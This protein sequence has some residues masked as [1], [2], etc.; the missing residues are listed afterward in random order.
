MART[1]LLVMPQFELTPSLA[2]PQFELT[3]KAL[4]NFSPGLERSDN[5]G[6]ANQQK[7]RTL[8]GFGNWRTL[9][10]LARYSIVNPWV[11]TALEPRA[12]ISQRL[13]R[14]FKLRHYSLF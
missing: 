9:S 3:P 7:D 11:L 8:K 2:M 1:F 13:R 4:A 10:G 5:P 14:Y 6:N 12:G